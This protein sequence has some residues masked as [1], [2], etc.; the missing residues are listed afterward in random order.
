MLAALAVQ[1]VRVV[2]LV[3]QQDQFLVEQAG[4]AGR[5]ALVPR[6]LMLHN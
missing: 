2:L 4:L 1:V 5:V 3:L 6:V